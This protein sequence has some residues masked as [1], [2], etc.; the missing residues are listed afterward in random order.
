MGTS[1]PTAGII[2]VESIH[3]KI[4]LVCLLLKKAIEYAAGAASSKPSTVDNTLVMT[5]FLAYNK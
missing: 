3:I 4:S 5:E 1:A 2:L